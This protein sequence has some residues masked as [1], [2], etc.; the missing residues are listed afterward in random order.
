MIASFLKEQL[1][2]EIRIYISP[3]I[4]GAQGSVNITE[5]LTEVSKAVGLHYVDIKRF[6]NDVC[7]SGFSEVALRELS[8]IKA[9]DYE[10]DES[11][12]LEIPQNE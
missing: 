1:A 8:I 6:G 5:P 10:E 12:E 11:F 7:L 3:K 4:L 9:I 2:D